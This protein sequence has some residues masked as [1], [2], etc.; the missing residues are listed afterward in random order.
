MQQLGDIKISSFKR[1][2]Q[3]FH[4]AKQRCYN[5]N[6]PRYADWGGRGIQVKFQTFLD[7]IFCLGKKPEGSSLDRI[8]NNGHYAA[9][10]VKWST[11]KEQQSNRRVLRKNTLGVNCVRKVRAKGLVTPTYQAY[12]FVNSKFKQLYAGPSLEEAVLARKTYER[13]NETTKK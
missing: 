7:F 6:H 1:E 2:Y 3:A 12:A 9:G 4:D 11:R 10:N 13:F 8:D 5:K